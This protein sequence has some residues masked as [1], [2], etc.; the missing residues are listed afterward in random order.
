MAFWEYCCVHNSITH[1]HY[2]ITSR[3]CVQIGYLDK[4]IRIISWIKIACEWAQGN[5]CINNYVDNVHWHSVRK[6]IYW[7]LYG[8]G[9]VRKVCSLREIIKLSNMKMLSNCHWNFASL[10]VNFTFFKSSLKS[11]CLKQLKTIENCPSPFSRLS[12]LS[13]DV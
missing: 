6:M 11:F 1:I 4:W 9:I 10:Q 5:H 2:F 7:R 13:S 3:N 12:R 8:P